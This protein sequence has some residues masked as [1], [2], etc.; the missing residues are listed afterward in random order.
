MSTVNK[1]AELL[2]I[3]VK[4]D[5]NAASM[6]AII[7]PLRPLFLF[8]TRIIASGHVIYKKEKKMNHRTTNQRALSS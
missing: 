3:E 4:S 6:T 2:K 1:V 7:R 5:I 8:T